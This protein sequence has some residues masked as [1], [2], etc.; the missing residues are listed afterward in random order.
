MSTTSAKISS[1]EP[2]DANE[3]GKSALNMNN[4]GNVAKLDPEDIFM[5]GQLPIFYR[6]PPWQ[7]FWYIYAKFIHDTL[8][9][10][11]G[12][13]ENHCV[14]DKPFLN[15][16]PSFWALQIEPWLKHLK[17]KHHAMQHGCTYM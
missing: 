8:L 5:L 3:G 11:D 2:A 9:L 15:T 10:N 13:W 1:S 7:V 14:E 12:D 6:P 16:P 17:N 4:L